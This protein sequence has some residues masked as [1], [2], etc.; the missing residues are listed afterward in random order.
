LF[1]G[2]THFTELLI[3]QSISF[4]PSSLEVLTGALAKPNL[5][6]VR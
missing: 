4:N 1:C 3:R 5:F 2:G 6:N